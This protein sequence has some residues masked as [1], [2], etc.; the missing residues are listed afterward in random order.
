MWTKQ[1]QALC[2]TCGRNTNHVTHY[3]KDNAGGSLVAEVQCAEH[4]EA[5]VR[6]EQYQPVRLTQAAEPAA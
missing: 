6:S 3:I 4:H 2:V 1:H 5:P